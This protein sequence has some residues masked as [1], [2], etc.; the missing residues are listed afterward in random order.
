[1]TAQKDRI[2]FLKNVPLF[3]DLPEEDLRHLADEAQEVRLSA[4]E[5]LFKEGS[6]G[7]RAYVIRDGLIEVVKRSAGRE[8]LL[9]LQEAPAVVGEMALIEDK[10]RMASVRARTDSVLLTITQ[11]HL[12]HLL[13]SSPSAARAMLYSILGRW[14]ATEAMLRQSEKMAELGTLTAGIA[15]EL[16]NPAAAVKRAAS[17][18]QSILK[19]YEDASLKIA[20][21]KDAE[22]AEL[23]EMTLQIEAKKRHAERLGALARS[24][25]EQELSGVLDDQGIEDS[26]ELAPSLV[27]MGFDRSELETLCGKFAR[28]H[29]HTILTWLSLRHTVYDVLNEMSQGATHISDIVKALKSYSYLDRAPVQ[30]VDIHEGLDNTLVILRHKLKSAIVINREYASDLPEIEAYGSELNQVWTNIIGNAADALDKG[31]GKICVRTRR[32][33]DGVIVEIE[34]NGPGIPEAIR[35]RVFESFF[36]TKPPGKGT[37]LGLNI[38]YNII[39]YKHRGELTFDSCPGKTTFRIWLPLTIPAS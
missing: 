30:S 16:N 28:S 38:S 21:L 20:Q 22:Q 24:D 6:P 7:D 19:Q 26:W 35:N 18:L 29:I 34:D 39:V 11:E 9:A 5:Q 13:Q 1:M 36:T 15:H 4:G 37:G 31:G 2:A 3:A 14:R 33:D 25:R 23:N 8:V 10:P 17:H 12:E 27:S 32:D